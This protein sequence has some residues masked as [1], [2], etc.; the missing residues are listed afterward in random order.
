[1]KAKGSPARLEAD[2]AAATTSSNISSDTRPGGRVRAPQNSNRQVGTRKTM[3]T[4]T[5][6]P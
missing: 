6:A 1:L 2:T 3:A 4:A 5:T